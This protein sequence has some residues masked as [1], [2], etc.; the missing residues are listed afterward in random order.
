MDNRFYKGFPSRKGLEDIYSVQIADEFAKADGI[1]DSKELFLE[2]IKRI[3]SFQDKVYVDQNVENIYALD[4]GCAI[5][6]VLISNVLK[7]II[8]DDWDEAFHELCYLV[9]DV[10]ILELR[11][12]LIIE[13]IY[14][15]IE[16][17]TNMA[18]IKLCSK[19]KEYESD[20]TADLQ[21]LRLSQTADLNLLT[22]GTMADRYK[23]AVNNVRMFTKDCSKEESKV[24][25]DYYI[26][27]VIASY[28]T[29]CRFFYLCHDG[30]PIF[31]RSHFPDE[32]IIDG[33]KYHIATSEHCAI[34]LSTIPI[35][36][37]PWNNRR[38]VSS[39][40]NLKDKEF[41]E[42]KSNHD[43]VFYKGLGFAVS[44]NGHHSVNAGNYWKKGTITAS[45]YDVT[46]AFPN[47]DTDGVVWYER[48]TG[49]VIDRVIDYRIAILY[50]IQRLKQQL[51]QI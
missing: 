14:S 15:F 40:I 51:H 49:N 30:S 20:I 18:W 43:A 6:H 21:K 47:I 48:N 5:R 44:R 16:G 33:K 1:I 22:E 25:F 38:T 35:V 11:F 34:D 37:N 46:Q 4:N 39:I 10:N 17:N 23:E 3:L 12:F 2:Q 24:L 36:V 41:I 8:V 42:D 28:I 26:Y 9:F 19:S 45:V 7:S 50:E 27:A 32:Y 31:N 29:S 13:Y